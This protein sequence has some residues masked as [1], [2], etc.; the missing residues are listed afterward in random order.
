MI[1]QIVFVLSLLGCVSAQNVSP[2]SAL[3]PNDNRVAAPSAK[4]H[5]PAAVDPLESARALM[6]DH[7]YVE[8]STAFRGIIDKNP[9]AMRAHLGLVESL[10][11]LAKLE[12]AEE[13]AKKA[14]ATLPNVAM[15]HAAYG[16]V[17]FR[18]GKF[19]EAE[20]EYRAA[21]KL[22]HTSAEGWYGL[23]S[24]YEMLSMYKHAKD[25]YARAHE[26]DP[27]N[28][29]LFRHWVDL[30]PYTERLAEVKKHAGD[31]P[32][33]RENDYIKFL[34]AAAEKKPWVLTSE[35]QRREIKMLPYGRKMAGTN[36]INQD[37][38]HISKGYAL[39]V[40]F[41]DRVS[42]ELLVD[43]GAG[44]ITIGRK[45]AEKIGV[46]KIA[47]SYIFGI[48]DQDP[49]PTYKG[50]VDK[51]S[52]GGVE[53]RNCIVTVSSKN[54]IADETGLIGPDV[55]RK[56]LITLDFHNWKMILSPLPRHP[57][58][59]V[60]FDE[61]A[62]DRYIAPEMQ[63]F[64]RVYMF[65]HDL[66]APV[67][68][69]D[70]AIGNFILDTGADLNTMSP[71]FATKVTKA[72]DDHEYR[73]SGVSGRVNNVLTGQKAI[74]QIAKMRIESHELPVF[75]TDRISASDGTEIAGFIGIRTLVQMKM[76]LDY[77]DGLVDLQVYEFKKATE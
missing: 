11:R 9:E 77:R 62:I 74:L 27:A 24:M 53:F 68:V 42:A 63:N 64:I 47:D 51:I 16:D 46:Q 4:D 59:D 58:G 15:V 69:N 29:K 39:D 36:D 19:A 71:R 31:H 55:F 21:L 34:S 3:Q 35:L 10:L 5:E 25:A 75:A 66:V 17:E 12:D 6:T 73:M 30:L 65:G 18:S 56:F 7:K 14:V 72:S 40:R 60:D 57:A 8:A 22:D 67:T 50:W 52:I 1:R 61:I 38:R 37:P 32:T 49:V 23:G 44:G 76:T 13:A 26:F 28:D 33:A 45:L 70:K 41:N 48:G 20:A 2:S 43:T 54:D